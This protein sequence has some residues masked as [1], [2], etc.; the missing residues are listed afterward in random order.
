MRAIIT[1]GG[2]GGLVTAMA[3]HQ[4][5]IGVCV[6][7]SVAEL[8][9]LGVGINLLPHC[10]RVLGALGVAERLIP[11]GVETQELCYFN[12][13]GQEIWREK[14]GRAAG[15]RWPQLAIHRGELHM[16]LLAH[17][18]EMLGPE[19]IV[20]GHHLARFEDQGGQVQ[21]ID[22]RSGTV[23]T[24]ETADLLVGTDGIHSTVRA[25][26]YPDEGAPV[27]NGA[28][29]W[30]GTTETA[31]FLSHRTQF[32]AGGAQ[33]FIGYP[34]GLSHG[35]ALTNWA[36]RRFVGAGDFRRGDWNRRGDPADFLPLYADWHFPWLDI[37]AVIQNADAIY[38]YPMVDRD[39]L[40]RWSFGRVTLLGDAAHPMYPLGSNGASQA[41][42]D[43]EALAQALSEEADVEAAL[44]RYET[45]R[46]PA[47]TQ[48]VTSNRAG[49]PEAVI[50]MVEERAP[51]GFDDLEQVMPRAELEAFASRYKQVAG[52]DLAAVNRAAVNRAAVN[53]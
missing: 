33:T 41:I 31:P 40:A 37:P 25:H 20:T 23:L 32:M 24:T 17:A 46:R 36:A 19:A 39:P 52:F 27:W 48:V 14:R 13:R 18:T 1:G 51:S 28:I 50:R 38:E 22:R 16:A 5:G 11:L 12:N 15:Y 42:L 44:S 4:A 3:L 30:R 53:R 10:M 2:I 47:T 45:Q 49:G 6:F 29:I 9:P 35:R 7:E 21:F 8:R 26:F 43:A 34:I